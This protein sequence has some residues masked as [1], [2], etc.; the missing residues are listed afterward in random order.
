MNWFS[1]QAKWLAVAVAVTGLGLASA[2]ADEP[3][4][5]KPIDPETVAAY[6]KLGAEYGEFEVT[7][8]GA[9]T[10]STG[11]DAAAKKLPGFCL[12]ERPDRMLPKLPAV[13][14]PFG[15]T[16]YDTGVK[17]EGL[18]EL[19]DLKNLTTLVLA[20]RMKDAGLKELKDLKN[21]TTLGIINTDVTDAGLKELKNL[22]KLVSLDL[23]ATKVTDAGLK[24][25]KDLKNL[26][27]LT[28][29]NDVTDAGLKELKE[30]LP[31][32]KINRAR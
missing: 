28:L 7:E 3:A 6:E 21:L 29:R 25:L 9:V 24:E 31:G 17:A 30:A 27:S 1:L 10:F 23:T 19:K 32:C 15:L 22:K 12:A 2:K 11:I 18:K 13:Q 16:L 26:T 4:K 20:K 8:F 14:V 5:Y